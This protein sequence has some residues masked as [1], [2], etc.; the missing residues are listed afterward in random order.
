MLGRTAWFFLAGR[1]HRTHRI[2][3]STLD[4]APDFGDAVQLDLGGG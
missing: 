2:A 3:G 1:V 4:L